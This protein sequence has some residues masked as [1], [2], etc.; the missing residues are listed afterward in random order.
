MRETE[1]LRRKIVFVETFEDKTKS[2]EGV[3]EKVVGELTRNF[4]E[5][6]LETVRFLGSGLDNDGYL[7]N[8][9][10]VFRFARNPEV[11]EATERE[12]K[13]L[14]YVSGELDGLTAQVLHK[15]FQENGARVSG[16]TYF[17]GT[18]LE[19]SLLSD[20][21]IAEMSRFL[22]KLHALPVESLRRSGID[23][24]GEKFF[25]EHYQRKMRNVLYPFLLSEMPHDAK[26]ITDYAEKLYTEY[27]NDE[28]NFS[29]EP[30]LVHADFVGEHIRVDL[31]SQK[32]IGVIDWGGARIGDPDYDLWRSYANYGED[33][34][35]KLLDTYSHEDPERL[36][37]K[38][39]FWFRSML[40]KR[41]IRDIKN[42]ATENTPRRIKKL[43]KHISGDAYF[44]YEL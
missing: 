19:R 27:L 26:L 40:L 9:K 35:N 31:E 39:D 3:P 38:L 32:I 42:G 8:E 33:F 12:F 36:R 25:V 34:L 14:E 13:V 43:K 16:Q 4:P 41:V 11:N 37:K 29:Y 23:D 1:C 28:Q 44:E 2:F 5:I 15:G 22:E 18:T 24:L 7:I 10:E 30:A 6:K 21:I 17:G 20:E